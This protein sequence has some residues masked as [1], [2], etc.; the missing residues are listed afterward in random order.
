[1]TR[2]F[3]RHDRILSPDSNSRVWKRLHGQSRALRCGLE[4]LDQLGMRLAWVPAHDH[5]RNSRRRRWLQA[6]RRMQ[7]AR[8]EGDFPAVREFVSAM[9]FFSFILL[10]GA[11]FPTLAREPYRRL[12]G[13]DYGSRF[14]HRSL[15][16]T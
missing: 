5:R 16:T 12:S 13:W 7:K 2:S 4:M 6:A 14:P 9:Q 3:F 10:A 15:R 1:M 11:Y 8:T